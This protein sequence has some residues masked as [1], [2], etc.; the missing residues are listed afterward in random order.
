MYVSSHKRPLSHHHSKTCS[1][2]PCFYKH[3]G[4]EPHGV[5]S[6]AVDREVGGS[7]PRTARDLCILNID[8]FMNFLISG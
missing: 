2:D 1:T 6:A 3:C 4:N 8:L 5:S 7:N